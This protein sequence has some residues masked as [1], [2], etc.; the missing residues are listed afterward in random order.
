MSIIYD[1]FYK[2][3]NDN[4]LLANFLSGFRSLQ[5]TLASLL[6]A[7]NSWSVNMKNGFSNGVIF[8]D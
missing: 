5:S 3:L 1:Q 6:E 8:I 4:E 7:T 2:Y